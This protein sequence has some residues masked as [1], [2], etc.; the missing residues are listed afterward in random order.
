MSWR[1]RSALAV[2]FLATLAAWVFVAPDK[3]ETQSPGG[4]SFYGLGG[5]YGRT[6]YSVDPT[7]GTATNLNV[8]HGSNYLVSAGVAAIGETV[9]L[10]TYS[11]SGGTE[12]RR[13]SVLDVSTGSRSLLAEFTS[14]HGRPFGLAPVGEDLYVVTDGKLLRVDTNDGTVEVVGS[15]IDTS[16][17]IGSGEVHSI[18]AI[19]SSLYAIDNASSGARLFSVNSSTGQFTLIGDIEEEDETEID[20]IFGLTSYNGLLYGAQASPAKF[21]SIDPA[22][23]QAT[24]I[25]TMTTNLFGM[26]VFPG[27]DGPDCTTTL[28]PATSLGT[29]GN[30][31]ASAIVHTGTLVRDITQ[32]PCGDEATAYYSVTLTEGGGVGFSMGGVDVTYHVLASSSYSA[33]LADCGGGAG[34]CENT[35]RSD[36]GGV[37][38]VSGE[39]TTYTFFVEGGFG[40][41]AE[42][43][44]TLTRLA[45]V[46]VEALTTNDSVIS[47]WDVGAPSEFLEMRVDYRESTASDWTLS[48]AYAGPAAG[49]NVVEN[50]IEDLDIGDYEL[51]G[52]FRHAPDTQAGPGAASTTPLVWGLPPTGVSVDSER[53]GDLEVYRYSVIATWQF[54]QVR[55]TDWDDELVDWSFLLRHN[56]T[57]IDVG[58]TRRVVFFVGEPG[59]LKV[60]MRVRFACPDSSTD[61]DECQLRIRGWVSS[62]A[63]DDD[64]DY[65][66]VPQG[67]TVLT[68]RSDA[69]S[70]YID[71]D[72]R[73]VETELVDEVA[74]PPVVDAISGFLAI[75][76]V[77]PESR[78]PEVWAFFV[79]LVGGLAIGGGLGFATGAAGRTSVSL[80]VGA[81]VFFLWWSLL[82]PAWFGI[83][84]FFAYGTIAA[85]I[86]TLGIV[87][88]GR[89]RL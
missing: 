85:P 50:T 6:L 76:G 70:V 88:V 12:S 77:A 60:D 16:L 39:S 57:E 58:R 83:P 71:P 61:D 48:A 4:V 42:Y 80:F 24:V 55:F 75:A 23:G 21:V 86:L 36:F 5:S 2:L 43:T 65:F 78:R 84:P 81:F 18:A 73:V 15:F 52:V 28:S 30:T 29:M 63:G 41:N 27:F 89:A 66:V 3:A 22:N 26:S 82:G 9:Y 11:V 17:S 13:V 67:F 49:D 8:T 37:F 33:D 38:T 59:R 19:G 56:G 87:V 69:A 53:V 31:A 34:T 10:A 45:P 7:D 64:H 74:I 79:C 72:P 14:S 46:F 44:L 35:I 54:P 25:G 1:F 20:F 32:I 47:S 68:P 40:E 51:R 62:Y